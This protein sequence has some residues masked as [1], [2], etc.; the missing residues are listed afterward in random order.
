MT[1]NFGENSTSGSSSAYGFAD[2]NDFTAYMNS[3]HL[4]SE[5]TDKLNASLNIAGSDAPGDYRD[6]GVGYVHIEPVTSVDTYPKANIVPS[7]LYFD[8]STGKYMQYSNNQWVQAD[9][10]RVDQVLKDKAY[11]DMPNLNYFTFLNPR[12]IFW[13]VRLTFDL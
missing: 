1:M 5:I 2:Q 12:N 8:H 6:F 7:A 3:L 13:G 9:Q 11:I 10:S 4:P